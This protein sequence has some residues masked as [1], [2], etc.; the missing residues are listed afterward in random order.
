MLQ[1]YMKRCLA[2]VSNAGQIINY[3]LLLLYYLNL[4]FVNT[5]MLVEHYCYDTIRIFIESG[6]IIISA[7]ILMS[8]VKNVCSVHP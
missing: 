1:I 3:I 7:M 5:N 8:I 6:D 4:G 2:A